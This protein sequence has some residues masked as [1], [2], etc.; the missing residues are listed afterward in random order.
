M[1]NENLTLTSFSLEKH[2]FLFPNRFNLKK[3]WVA[4][5]SPFYFGLCGGMCFSALDVY[6]NNDQAPDFKDPE[7]LPKTLLTHLI[8]RQLHSTG[9]RSLVKL[10]V[11]LFQPTTRLFQTSINREL[12]RILQELSAGH[13][14]PIILIR[15][16]N[17]QKPTNN[18]QILITGYKTENEITQLQAY[19]PNYPGC[20]TNLRINQAHHNPEI[21][22]STGEIVRGFFVNYYKI[23]HS[24]KI[25]KQ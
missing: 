11:G 18:H 9:F 17:L 1:K 10:V 15:S 14:V 13:P 4:A 12:P 20:L 6:Y 23:K 24:E 2:G 3:K 8:T 21:I 25:R 7:S 19:D 5:K 16:K 22:Q